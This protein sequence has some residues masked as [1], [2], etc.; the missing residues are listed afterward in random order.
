MI[1]F[2]LYEDVR[3]YLEVCK[4]LWLKNFKKLINNFDILNKTLYFKSILWD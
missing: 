1:L 3:E 2:I 4:L